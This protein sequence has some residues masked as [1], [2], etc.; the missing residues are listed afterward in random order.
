MKNKGK[1]IALIVWCVIVVVCFVAARSFLSAV[2]L[3][4]TAVM[5]L[6][7]VVSVKK[8]EHTL[9]AEL[10]MPQKIRQG[11]KQSGRLLIRN[12]GAFPMFGVKGTVCC[13]YAEDTEIVRQD[14]TCA[15]SPYQREEIAVKVNSAVVADVHVWVEKLTVYD[16]FGLF[17]Y[18]ADVADLSADA[19]VT[20]APKDGAPES[21]ADTQAAP[22]SEEKAEKEASAGGEDRENPD[23]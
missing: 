10:N 21:E 1:R 13:R 6:F 18:N 15:I 3:L 9:Q 14:F 19:V 12:N 4:G 8:S 7:C 22:A 11:K 20:E 17:Q 23:E 2:L 5:L 16:V